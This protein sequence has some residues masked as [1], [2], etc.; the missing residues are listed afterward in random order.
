M[1]ASSCGL[2]GFVARNVL[3]NR[4]RQDQRI[5]SSSLG[6][7][8]HHARA[9]LPARIS[10]DIKKKGIKEDCALS[11]AVDGIDGLLLRSGILVGLVGLCDGNSL[12]ECR[13]QGSRC[14]SGA[15]GKHSVHDD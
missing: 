10:P 4:Y 1:A 9:I 2:V 7:V 12:R 8:V 11:V 3:R 15:L 5:D 13:Q 14:R 6:D